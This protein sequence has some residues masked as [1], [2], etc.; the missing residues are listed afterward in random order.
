MR[1]LYLFLICIG[2]GPGS[3]R[4]RALAG[5]AGVLGFDHSSTA[6]GAIPP[7]NAMTTATATTTLK[8]QHLIDPEICIRCNTCEATCPVGAVTHD[9]VNYVVDPEKCNYC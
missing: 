5:G 4:C 2:K 9:D 7:G 3:P 8:K 1:G 6:N